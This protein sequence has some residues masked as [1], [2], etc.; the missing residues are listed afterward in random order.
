MSDLESFCSECGER[1]DSGDGWFHV[2]TAEATRVISQPGGGP[3]VAAEWQVHHRRCSSRLDRGRSV[4]W[5]D[6]EEV[7][8]WAGLVYR[9]ALLMAKPWL[10][11]TDWDELLCEASGT[12][13]LGSR[14]RP[15]GSGAVAG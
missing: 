13:L 7:I 6:V 9:T 5:I 12:G 3:F 1:V 10:E 4:Y 14:L 2:D 11:G 8:S 15:A